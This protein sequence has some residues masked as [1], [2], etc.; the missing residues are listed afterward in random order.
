MCK[1]F[2]P[3]VHIF[4]SLETLTSILGYNSTNVCNSLRNIVYDTTKGQVEFGGNE[5]N[6]SL[7]VWN[8]QRKTLYGKAF[9]VGW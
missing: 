1:S 3:G 8:D 9:G 6:P 5:R 4:H 7:L 2:T